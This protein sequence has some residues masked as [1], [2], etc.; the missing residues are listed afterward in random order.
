MLDIS[1]TLANLGISQRVTLGDTSSDTNNSSSSSGL[2][3]LFATLPPG[4]QLSIIGDSG[5]MY[6]PGQFVNYNPANELVVITESN[7]ITPVGSATSFIDVNK[8]E[9]ITFTS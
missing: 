1:Q 3:N 2:K 8:I 6:G 4:S 5:F 9:S 7:N